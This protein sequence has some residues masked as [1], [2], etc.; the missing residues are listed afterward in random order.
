M[1]HTRTLSR[2][3][4]AAVIVIAA[5]LGGCGPAQPV[6]VKAL[7]NRPDLVSGGDVLIEL[8]LPA[9]A[10]PAGLKVDVDGRDVTAAFA[11]RDG[12]MRGV[13]EGLAV[14]RNRISAT[15]QGAATGTLTVT[16]APPGGPVLSGPQATPFVCATPVPQPATGD[17][18]ATNG[19]G[20]HTQARDAQCDIATE[21]ALY[22]K[23]TTEGCVF[24]LPDP[25][26]TVPAFPPE[27][28][29]A[30]PFTSSSP[31]KP[32]RR[33]RTAASSCTILPRPRPPTSRRLPRTQARPCRTS[34]VWSA[35]C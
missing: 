34:C 19:S 15:A 28:R 6:G 22:Y 20:L 13:V 11:A 24:A 31:P 30:V 26:P 25:S 5:F 32:P 14:G 8:T 27:P 10:T 7:S 3:V 18:P 9:G 33:L 16:N 17:L 23:S 4:I 2:A 21:Y 29:Q 12:R 35:A 1:I